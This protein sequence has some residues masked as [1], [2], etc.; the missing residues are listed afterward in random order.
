[1]LRGHLSF[2]SSPLHPAS[3]PPL[4]RERYPIHLTE[5]GGVPAPKLRP[6]GARAAERTQRG[7][8]SR[9]ETSSQLTFH[10]IRVTMPAREVVA[11]LTLKRL[12]TRS[13]LAT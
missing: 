12:A 3:V 5:L 10:L 2:S 8:Q 7:A 1:V 4:H 13:D 6:L 9:A 11:S